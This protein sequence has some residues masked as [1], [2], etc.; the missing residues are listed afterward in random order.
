MRERD[1]E[2]VRRITADSEIRS[3]HLISGGGSTVEQIVCASLNGELI[4]K[5]CPVGV[6]SSRPDA[7]GIAKAKRLGVPA[8]VV[9]RQHYASVEAF[10]EEIIELAQAL[11]ADII[12]QNGWLR[13]TP[14]NVIDAYNG[15]IFNQHPA[16]LDLD[17]LGTNGKPK[18]FGGKGMH[19]L[20]AHQAVL[21]FQELTQ[22][23]FPTEA[24]IHHVT[25]QVDGGGVVFRRPIQV[26][27]SDTA[28]KLAAR[29]LPEEHIAHIIFLSELQANRVSIQHR[30]IPLIDISEEGILFEAKEYATHA[31]P[32]G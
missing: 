4:G 23:H 24:T 8:F 11:G 28:E 22:R 17:F 30:S 18:H 29:V 27:E 21:K 5:I 13:F 20:A 1:V 10:G 2:Q 26:H 16:P 32:K 7:G 9:E 25:T 6:I 3:V 14:G 19:G 31:Y 12:M 15:R